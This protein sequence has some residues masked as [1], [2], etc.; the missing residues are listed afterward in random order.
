MIFGTDSDPDSAEDTNPN[1]SAANSV[2][3]HQHQTTHNNQVNHMMAATTV[4]L[5]Q[6]QHSSPQP[7]ILWH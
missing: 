5:P 1:N 6:Q 3:P 2:A 7:Q 4:Q